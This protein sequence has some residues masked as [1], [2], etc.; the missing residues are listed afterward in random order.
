MLW[1]AVRGGGDAILRVCV[2]AGVHALQIGSERFLK[3]RREADAVRAGECDDGGS[4][5]PR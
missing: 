2:Y 3:Y 4:F 1:R 5:S